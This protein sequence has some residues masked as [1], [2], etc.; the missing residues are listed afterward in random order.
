VPTS[1]NSC[2]QADRPA[3][4]VYP[5]A[6]TVTGHYTAKDCYACHRPQT[7]TITRFNFIHGNALDQNITFCLP[8]HLSKGQKVHGFNPKVSFAGDGNCYDCHN[9]ARRSWAR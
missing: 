9:K 1:C 3:V 4:A 2:H 5:G 6:V 8:C 7:A